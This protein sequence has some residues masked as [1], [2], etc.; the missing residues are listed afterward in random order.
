MVAQPYRLISLAI[1]TVVTMVVAS[2]SHARGK[3]SL[4]K[5]GFEPCDKYIRFLECYITQLPQKRRGAFH[6]RYRNQ[7]SRLK[8]AYVKEGSKEKAKRSLL[9]RCAA[10]FDMARNNLNSG[11]VTR[12]L[13][14]ASPHRKAVTPKVLD[15]PPATPQR[16][17]VAVRRRKP[18]RPATRIRAR[19]QRTH[20]PV[21]RSPRARPRPRKPKQRCPK[22]TKLVG[23]PPPRGSSEWCVDRRSKKHGVWKWWWSNGKLREVCSYR[24]GKKD[25]VCRRFYKDSA[26]HYMETYRKGVL[27][28]TWEEWRFGQS[29]TYGKYRRGKRHG[30]WTI[31]GGDMSVRYAT[32]RMGTLHGPWRWEQSDGGVINKRVGFYR[33]GKMDGLWTRFGTCGDAAAENPD[34]YVMKESERRY[35]HGVLHGKFAEWECR[36]NPAHRRVKE[37][38]YRFGK[39]HGLFR[40]YYQGRFVISETRYRNGRIHG[41]SVDRCE[42][43]SLSSKGKYANGKQSGTWTT[44]RCSGSRKS[45]QKFSG[46][47]LNGPSTEWHRNGK[48]S[49][50]GSFTRGTKTGRWLTWDSLGRRRCDA[51]YRNGKFSGKIVCW[52]TNGKAEFKGNYRAGAKHSRWRFW[53]E[54]GRLKSDCTFSEGRSMGC[55]SSGKKHGYWKHW[56]TRGTY[57]RLCKYRRGKKL[58]CDLMYYDGS[59]QV[60]GV[61]ECDRLLALYRC[62]Q[63]KSVREIAEYLK[64]YK[65]MISMTRRS[66][67]AVVR[68]T[69]KRSLRHFY[70]VYTKKRSDAARCWRK[71][72][73]S[74]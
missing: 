57:G 41:L 58:K 59:L 31:S 7:I 19:P 27:S 71:I 15:L 61:A 10:A 45:V 16:R 25:G 67:K 5:I 13:K 60:V 68:T 49:A 72:R 30:K 3:Y 35:R 26:L 11:K 9:R 47:K 54:T 18:P 70:S 64:M 40:R 22:G 51:R 38:A 28:G 50:K 43:G 65:A 48:V 46:G 69:C 56:P 6:A 66:G 1:V 20:R 23:A 33:N 12:C 53:S 62:I 21:S 63:R 42:N 44:W 8:W 37:G 55:F 2:D 34:T 14:A 29:W 74:P 4:G 73:A 32:Y 24:R 39:K 36:K 52:Y 17:R